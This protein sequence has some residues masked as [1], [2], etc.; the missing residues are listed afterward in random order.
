MQQIYMKPIE[1]SAAS[2]QG[3]KPSDVGAV[4]GNST[5][6]LS[7]NPEPL[8]KT[9]VLKTTEKPIRKAYQDVDFWR[10]AKY[11]DFQSLPAKSL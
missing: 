4:V 2:Q 8:S 10:K 3:R 9:T 1:I 11:N 5:A 6:K 7:G